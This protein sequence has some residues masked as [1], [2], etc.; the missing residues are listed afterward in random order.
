M[1]AALVAADRFV[2][3]G[4]TL[5]DSNGFERFEVDELSYEFYSADKWVYLTQQ[6]SAFTVDN[7]IEETIGVVD[8][9]R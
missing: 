4:I 8:S 3:E 2:G 9:I 7:F 6:T 5:L 1:M